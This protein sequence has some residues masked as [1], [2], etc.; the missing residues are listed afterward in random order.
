MKM[1]QLF[2]ERNS[3]NLYSDILGMSV[4]LCACVLVQVYPVLS[5]PPACF[6]HHCHKHVSV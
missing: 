6:H 3:V 4:C 5:L 1:G 2:I